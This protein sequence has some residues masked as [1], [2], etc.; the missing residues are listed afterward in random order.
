MHKLNSNIVIGEEAKKY[1]KNLRDGYRS[2]LKLYKSNKSDPSKRV[3]TWKYFDQMK[4]LRPYMRDRQRNTNL[5]AEY[6]EDTDIPDENSQEQRPG[7][8]VKE[9]ISDIFE[10][11]DLIEFDN[12]GYF[13]SDSP[14]PSKKVCLTAKS[15]NEQIEETEWS[16]SDLFQGSEDSLKLFFDSMY[17]STKKLSPAL[18][19]LVK[20]KLFQAVNDAEVEMEQTVM[21]D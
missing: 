7:G 13:Q 5:S 10:T 6:S 12:D 19:R 3:K 9:E 18:Q 11:P 16:H 14:T 1:W 21:R 2:A 4:F 8:V 15:R 17:A 20:N